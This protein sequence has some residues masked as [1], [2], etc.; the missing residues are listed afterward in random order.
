MGPRPQIPIGRRSSEAGHPDTKTTE[1]FTT[2]V[3]PKKLHELAGHL[4]KT[5]GYSCLPLHSVSIIPL[6]NPSSQAPENNQF[7]G[8]SL[9]RAGAEGPEVEMVK[10]PWRIKG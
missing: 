4:T 9:Q 8:R 10:F 3:E 5:K 7:L 6:T 2:T 1:D